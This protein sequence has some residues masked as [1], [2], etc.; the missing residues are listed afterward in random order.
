M[1]D[2]DISIKLTCFLES[3]ATKPIY[4][5]LGLL[6]G[7]CSEGL[8]L[9][10]MIQPTGSAIQCEGTSK[11]GMLEPCGVRGYL[12]HLSG[13]VGGNGGG[14]FFRATSSNVQGRSGLHLEILRG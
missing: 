6:S 5:F 13:T 10:L 4:L 11:L 7:T 3:N 1:E 8:G 14:E 12:G 9:L 2:K